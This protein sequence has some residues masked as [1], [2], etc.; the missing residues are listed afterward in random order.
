MFKHADKGER[1]R[2]NFIHRLMI[3]FL[4][5]VDPSSISLWPRLD[6][7]IFNILKER[8]KPDRDFIT[9]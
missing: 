4:E 3:I 9:E 6:T 5:D 2:T 1:I 7:L 8:K